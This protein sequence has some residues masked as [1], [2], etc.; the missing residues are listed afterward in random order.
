MRFFAAC[1]RFL[2]CLVRLLGAGSGR[3]STPP[4]VPPPDDYL[5]LLKKHPGTRVTT[6][7]LLDPISAGKGTLSR[8]E[9][10][11]TEDD[12][13][14]LRQIDA[15]HAPLCSS[16]HVFS[17]EVQPK[18][19][20]WICGRLMCSSEGCAGACA[21]CGAACC[22]DHRRTYQLD[23][24]RQVIYCSRCRWRHWWKLWWGLY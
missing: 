23:E 6:V 13:G 24:E 10:I 20:C 22:A 12:D 14:N 3:P 5:D 1:G 8:H 4:T 11:E 21:S 16:N 15:Y 19:V 18:G 7:T 9:H 17:R 2:R